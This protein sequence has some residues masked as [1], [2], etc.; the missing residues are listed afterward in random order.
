MNLARAIDLDR[1]AKK[2]QEHESRRL[3]NRI[4]YRLGDSAYVV[5]Y[6][7]GAA[8][9]LGTT[10]AE[11]KLIL[12][13]IRSTLQEPEEKGWTD[14][15]AVVVDPALAEAVVE[16][17]RVQIP[18]LTLDHVDI[19]CR[20]LA[21]SVV[22]SQ[23]D[24]SID[25][26]VE[27]FRPIQEALRTSGR[28]RVRPR[29]LLRMIGTNDSILRATIAD[30]ALLNAPQVAWQDPKLERLWLDL[31]ELFD[32]ADRFERLEFKLDYLRETT[33][34]LLNIVSAR[35]MELM[36]LAI[37]IFCAIDVVIFILELLK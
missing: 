21:Q 28:L 31:R 25:Q 7:F 35:R 3:R 18:E 26:M 10:P 15:Y 6:S 24:I 4:I 17:E 5:I 13:F 1:A 9:F 29:E 11:E 36:E 37:V 20:I 32:I 14:T 16:F 2:L 8:V 22:I 27:Q 34:Q 33:N 12:R 23:Y 19:I 30:L